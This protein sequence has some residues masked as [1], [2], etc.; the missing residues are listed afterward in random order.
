MDRAVRSSTGSTAKM[1]RGTKMVRIV[2]ENT[3]RGEYRLALV[4]DVSPLEDGR[5]H[6]VMVHYKSYRTKES[7]HE[8]RGARDTAVIRAVQR[9]AL[10]VPVD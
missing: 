2:A 1:V 6:N 10:L 9:L 4:R 7:V 3:L 8:Y 5:V